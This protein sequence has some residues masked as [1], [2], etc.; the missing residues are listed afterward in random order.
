MRRWLTRPGLVLLAV[1]TAVAAITSGSH[2]ATRHEATYAYGSATRQGIDAY[3]YDSSTPLPALL[4]LHG[5]YFNSGS[6]TDWASTAR[7]FADH[8]FAVF[9]ADYRYN[10]DAAWPGPRDDALAAVAWIK[11]H[12]GDFDAD[13]AHVAV[14]GSQAGG[15]L[16]TSLAT[17]GAGRDH[18]DAA[19]GLS[20]INSPYRAWTQAPTTS[21]TAT[22][23]KIRDETVILNRCYPDSADTDC[24]NRWTDSVAKT[25]A[26][27]ADDAPLYLVHSSG[28][29]I[30]A[31]HST[32]LRDAE[33]A[34]GANPADITVDVTSGS[35]SG[36]P[37]LTTTLKNAIVI[38]L[39]ART[40]TTTP[41]PQDTG[42]PPPQDTPTPRTTA[43]PITTAPY[44]DDPVPPPPAD[45]NPLRSAAVTVTTGTYSY[46]TD[47]KQ[48]LDAYYIPGTKQPALV[49]IHGGYWYEDDKSSWVATSQWYAERGYA[50]FSINYRLNAQT[51]WTAQRTDALNAIAWVKAHATQFSTDP[52][53]VL[54]LGSSAG[55]QI[56][57]AVGTYGTGTK[58]VRGVVALSPVASPYR[59]YTDGQKS[60]ASTSKQ[61]L[62][63]NSTLLARC[64]PTKTDTTCWNRWTDAVVKN[65]ASTSDA[66]M[67]LLHSQ[68]DFVPSTHSSDLCTAL[69]AKSVSCTL[70][71]VT[72]SGHASAILKV[73]GIHTKILNWLQ[74]HD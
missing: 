70:T 74:A 42:N 53:R 11:T 48:Q 31:A 10:T 52:N 9:S 35:S 33:T 65:H 16:A 29:P 34:K 27:G 21:A 19:V 47:P 54:L 63:D 7:Y 73:D 22:R 30:P 4:I 41:P 43:R 1:A 24:W 17:Y 66:P 23:R 2:A 71:V 38:W 40:H 8:G 72:G 28:D 50:V 68:G 5:G 25:H 26:S 45:E 59:A 32:D 64:Y 49:I 37:L 67:Y 57:T 20:P 36:G 6:K 12:A 39:K 14:L 55:G 58:Y 61:K 60:G 62:R 46:G 18:V 69:K 3:W 13:P 56:A 51:G 44:K 15:H